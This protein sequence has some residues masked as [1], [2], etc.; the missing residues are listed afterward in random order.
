MERA[1][2][3]PHADVRNQR[4]HARQHLVRRLVRECHGQN[5]M[6]LHAALTDEPGNTIGDHARLPRSRSSQHEERTFA[7]GNRFT[8]LRVEAGEFDHRGRIV[9]VQFVHEIPRPGVLL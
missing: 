5:V 6:R 4:L 7:V 2:P 8:L 3:R 9:T 1:D